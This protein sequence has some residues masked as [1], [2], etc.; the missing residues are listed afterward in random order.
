[1][2]T[3]LN[4][5]RRSVNI[6]YM[7]G[8]DALL[9]GPKRNGR[10]HRLFLRVRSSILAL[11]STRTMIDSVEILSR[12]PPQ[13]R[14]DTVCV[15]TEQATQRHA[16]VQKIHTGPDTTSGRSCAKYLDGLHRRRYD[17]PVSCTVRLYSGMRLASPL[18]IGICVSVAAVATL[19]HRVG[20]PWTSCRHLFWFFK[21]SVFRPL[22]ATHLFTLFL[23]ILLDI[24]VFYSQELVIIQCF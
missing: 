14:G 1:M 8:F 24:L 19:S 7:N 4:N 10:S 11:S 5:A 6:I 21:T 9:K 2:K 13:C 18:V 23:Q 20:L 16:T 17:S 3:S 22:N 12:L 15:I